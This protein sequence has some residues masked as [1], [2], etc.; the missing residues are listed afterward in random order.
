[1]GMMDKLERFDQHFK[2]GEPFTLEDARLGPAIP[3]EY[4]TD[5]P[6]QYRIGGKW[7]TVFGVGLA[8]QIERMDDGDR[9]AMSAGTFRV[10]M[11]TEPTRTPGKRVKVLVPADQ[12]VPDEA[13]TAK[14]DDDI[15]F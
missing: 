9:A 6:A 4:G 11:V 5:R 2:M 8:N 10:K 3:T 1:M 14:A 7:Y 12:P 15:P 13:V